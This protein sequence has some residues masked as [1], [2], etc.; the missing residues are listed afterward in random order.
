MPRI[1]IEW[2]PVQTFGLGLLGFDHLQLVYQP[3]DTDG[4]RGQDAWFVMEGV[5][6]AD[7]DLAFLGIEGADGRTTLSVANLAARDDLVT[8]IG[9]P[10]HRGS[11]PLPYGGDEF[12]AWETMA[13]Y[14]RDIEKQDFPYIAYSLPGSPTPTINSSSAIASLIYYSGLDPSAR[15]PFGLHLSP[16]VATRLGT[17]GDDAMRVENGFTTL[18]GGQGRDEFVGGSDRQA[19]DK[20]YGGKGDDL[21]HWSA[22][23]NV[24]H[25]GQPQLD[26]ADDGTDTVDYSGAGTVTITFNRHWVPH[27]APN[28]VAT[29]AD[30]RDHLYSIERIQWNE[31]TDRIVLGDG[32]NIVEDNVILDPGDRFERPHLKSGRLIDDGSTPAN[33]ILG[34]SGDDILRGT[35]GADTLY[36]G[37]GNDTLIG[38]GG[39][40]GY[41]Y[42]PG[43][44]NDVIIEDGESSDVDELILAGGIAP[45]DVSLSRPS[46][47]SEDLVLTL[48]MGGRIL[49]KDFFKGA[50]AIERVV[51]DN[52]PAWEHEKLQRLA[53]SARIGDGGTPMMHDDHGLSGPAV[54]GLAIEPES[55]AAAGYGAQFAAGNAHT[56]LPAIDVWPGLEAHASWLF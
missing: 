50:G 22:G 51:F 42:L 45:A 48:D 27:K 12:Q 18:L 36:G 15:P 20:L 41:V 26:Y 24:I 40:D 54:V 37:A 56:L 10:E 23:F 5:R 33:Q 17:S 43:D 34:D 53:A 32:V 47:E 44:G 39:S 6:E 25:G 49:I 1:R 55:A 4:P 31:T 16:G 7:G 14:A 3:G 28:Y 9:T 38:G 11:R 46:P 21:F 30:G 8:K 52:A 19:I 35:A 29:F 2:V 13:S